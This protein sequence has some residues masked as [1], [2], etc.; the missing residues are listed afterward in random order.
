MNNRPARRIAKSKRGFIALVCLFMASVAIVMAA[1]VASESVTRLAMT[2]RSND[3]DR[4]LCIAEAG[5]DYAVTLLKT[6]SDFSGD[7]VSYG[8]GTFDVVVS[9]GAVKTIQSTGSLPNGTSAVV[10]LQVS[11]GAAMQFPNGAIVA[12]GDVDLGGQA[13]SVTTPLGYHQASVYSNGNV[14]VRGQA[15]VDG[16]VNAHGTVTLDGQPS[17]YG[18]INSGAPEV[19]FP[20]RAAHDAWQD[21]L[22]TTAMA[23]SWVNGTVKNNTTWNSPVYID[24]DLKVS[25]QATLTI[26]GGGVVYVKGSI[27]LSGQSK[28]INSGILAAGGKISQ[29]GQAQYTISGDPSRVAIVSFE[30]N[31][32]NSAAIQLAGQASTTPMGLVY[33]ANGGI[34]LSGQGSVYGALVAAGENSRGFV[35]ISGQGDL[36]YP[37]DLLGTS[38]VIPGQFEI[39]S[40]LER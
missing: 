26:L 10:E 39:R 33:A 40:W 1:S 14:A 36:H 12:R 18:G 11:T 7:S 27:S 24:G 21:E 17:V 25:S 29:A 3:R 4:A 28:I 30:E 5:T 22:K 6:D 19:E 37:H 34:K 9:G 16:S 32:G 20:T 23:G 2:R 15:E 38:E 35:H 8:G 31:S 13:D